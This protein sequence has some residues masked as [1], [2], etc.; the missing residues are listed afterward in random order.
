MSAKGFGQKCREG[1]EPP[2]VCLTICRQTNGQ[3]VGEFGEGLSAHTAR[4]AEGRAFDVWSKT[5]CP[6]SHDGEGDGSMFAC[7]DHLHDR[8]SFGADR[9]AVGCIFHVASDKRSSGRSENRSSDGIAGIRSMGVFADVASCFVESVP[10]DG[11]KVI[12]V[13]QAGPRGQ[14]PPARSVWPTSTIQADKRARRRC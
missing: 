13:V 6:W 10:V 11:W 8:G 12:F 7:G 14:G 2:R 5:R 1:R 3:I 9:Q 4:R